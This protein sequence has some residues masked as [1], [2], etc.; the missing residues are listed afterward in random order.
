MIHQFRAIDIAMRAYLVTRFWSDNL[1]LP[2]AS[3][4]EAIWDQTTSNFHTNTT[5]DTFQ[6]GHSGMGGEILDNYNYPWR[7]TTDQ[8][9][10]TD[11]IDIKTRWL[12]FLSFHLYVFS[13]EM[14]IPV[15]LQSILVQFYLPV[16]SNFIGSFEMPAKLIQFYRWYGIQMDIKVIGLPRAPSVPIIII[17]ISLIVIFHDLQRWACRMLCL[18]SRWSR[19]VTGTWQ[20]AT[21]SEGPVALVMHCFRTIEPPPSPKEIL[22]VPKSWY[23]GQPGKDALNHK[24][25]LM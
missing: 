22:H 9:D 13:I 6:A 11:T 2:Y 18:G 4:L 1:Q 12:L 10:G 15:H 20:S 21:P 8:T 5:I 17:R 23:I 3:K 24:T 7:G 19:R 25:N 16:F 14:A